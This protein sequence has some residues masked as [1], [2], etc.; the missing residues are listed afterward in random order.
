NTLAQ[1]YGFAPPVWIDNAESATNILPTRGQQIRLVGS[2]RERTLRGVTHASASKEA[3]RHGTGASGAQSSTRWRG[4]HS[5][6]HV[7]A[8]HRRRGRGPHQ[9]AHAER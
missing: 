9:R 5:P 7:E 3:A 6:G 1:H 8:G 2:A 4:Y